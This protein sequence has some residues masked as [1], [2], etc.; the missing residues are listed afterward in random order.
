MAVASDQARITVALLR[1]AV[2]AVSALAPRVLAKASDLDPEAKPEM[3]LPMRLYG[4]CNLAIAATLLQG[5]E[6]EQQRWL[7]YGVA[8]DLFDVAAVLGGG[9]RG[10]LPKRAVVVGTTSALGLAALGVLAQEAT[11]T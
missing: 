11:R 10:E 9:A 5:D 1:L 2:G 7:G 6:Q 4:A 3:L 8:I